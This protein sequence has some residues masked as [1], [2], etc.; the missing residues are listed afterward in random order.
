MVSRA[1]KLYVQ[2]N[3]MRIRTH[4]RTV[5]AD[6]KQVLHMVYVVKTERKYNPIN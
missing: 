4:V 2:T 3:R 6:T 1:I 5:L